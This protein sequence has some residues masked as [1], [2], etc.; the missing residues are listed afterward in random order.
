MPNTHYFATCPKNLEALLAQ[1]LSDLG[2]ENIKQTVA[3]VAFE[4][5]AGG[6]PALLYRVCY[7]SRLA[8]RVLLP[9]ASQKLE[10][11]DDLYTFVNQQNWAQII[12]EGASLRVDFNGTNALIRNSHFGALAVKDAI[13]DDLRARRGERPGIDKRD[14]DMIINARLAKN[15]LHLAVDLSGDSLHRRGYR[16]DQGEAP[17]KENL[18]AALLLRA[19][20][21]QSAQKGEALFDPM[22]GSG[23]FLIEGAMMAADMAPGLLRDRFGFH[24][25]SAFNEALF[26]DIK[27]EAIEREKQGL[28]AGLPEIRGYDQDP[29]MIAIAEKNIHAAGLDG[30]VRVSCKALAHF[31]K[32]THKQIGKGLM[33]CN[34][35]YGER[36]GEKDAL[37]ETYQQLA[38]VV[39]RELCDW[40]LAVFTANP[41]LAKELRLR[42]KNKYKFFNGAL[43][44]ELLLFDIVDENQASL[45]P[46][47]TIEQGGEDEE[48]EFQLSDNARMLANRLR[49]NQKRLASWLKQEQHSCY[50]LY[51]ADLPEYAAAI[52]VYKN[53]L[54]IQEYAAPASIDEDKAAQRFK[55]ILKVSAET[56]G[57][58]ESHVFAKQRQRNRGKQQYEKRFKGAPDQSHYF[59]VSEG[60]ARFYVNLQDYL[61]T[62]LFLDHRPLRQRIFDEAQGKR[63]LNLF[64]YTA[65]ATVHAALGGAV[66]SVSVDM[67]NT[68]LEWATRNF[69]LNNIQG[70]RH[71]LVRADCFSWLKNCR[72]GFD[73][74]MLDPP[75][76]SNSKK[77]EGVLDVQRDHASLVNRCMDLLLPGG[78][79]YF[80]NNFRKF[81]LDAKIQERFAV[82]DMKEKSLDKDFAQRANIHH[83]WQIKHK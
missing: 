7:W 20:W 17:L 23:T 73:L 50:R 14:P 67:S 10:K 3:G 59:E 78:T 22:C 46:A 64:C 24:Y 79:L 27:E 61:D 62:G 40:Q 57:I 4:E 25:W 32:P 45:K 31:V 80:S 71:E 18:A 8:N 6:D 1:E 51:D 69:K 68:Y 75:S 58:D 12:R 42:A 16:V 37:R 70:Q 49:K 26:R 29:R 2:A 55:E 53:N 33:I 72:Q 15:V 19:G 82:E 66:S 48:P 43:A 81:K 5:K 35:P 63:F 41:D 13:V 21:P 65:T 83:C 36:L 38:Q 60:K 52:D 47:A 39:K 28:Q 44:S 9:L 11:A 74:I 76:F 34:P 30:H 56:L 77:M 54:H